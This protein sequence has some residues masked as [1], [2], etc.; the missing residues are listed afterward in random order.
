MWRTRLSY[1]TIFENMKYRT[2]PVQYLHASV[3]TKAFITF[4]HVPLLHSQHTNYT[5]SFRGVH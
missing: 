5:F 3:P 4:Y 2:S 1:A